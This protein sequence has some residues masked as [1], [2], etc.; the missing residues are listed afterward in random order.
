MGAAA[1]RIWELTTV[2][3]TNWE[4]H[5]NYLP[6]VCCQGTAYFASLHTNTFINKQI[7]PASSYRS[8][9]VIGKE[10]FICSTE[11]QQK[12]DSF[13]WFCNHKK[14]S[15]GTKKRM[16]DMP[17]TK[18]Y[19][20]NFFF[21][22]RNCIFYHRPNFWSEKRKKKNPLLQWLLAANKCFLCC[23]DSV[24]QTIISSILY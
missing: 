19:C 2:G 7:D 4:L 22:F 23:S 9:L 24:R 18:I 5:S 17:K 3:V 14:M 15:H 21:F 6:I 11:S 20:G 16:K 1:R 8:C 10:M 13:M 12:R